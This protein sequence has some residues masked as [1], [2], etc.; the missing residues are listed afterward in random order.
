VKRGFMNEDE[1]Q[2]IHAL[3][4]IFAIACVELIGVQLSAYFFGVV[5][6]IGLVLVHLKLSGFS[7]GLLE[8]LVE[9][10]DRPGVTP[11]YGAM[12]MVAGIL[13]ILTL[14][15]GRGEI[16]A[17]L[18]I[19]GVGDSASNIFGRRSKRKLPYSRE[20]TWGGT[21]AFFLFSLPAVYF[22]GWAAIPVAA[23]AAAVES[24][25]SKIDDNL[26]IAVVCVVLFRLIG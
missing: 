1:R 23:A 20:K 12:T 24:M 2:I 21:L 8:Q 16:L 3:V 18:F 9:R 11:G 4:G 15:S 22:A 19:L 6:I 17:S 5:L 13:A 14:L 7:L 25:E 26:S 10:F